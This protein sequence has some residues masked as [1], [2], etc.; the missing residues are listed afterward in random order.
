MQQIV[1]NQFLLDVIGQQWLDLMKIILSKQ[2]TTLKKHTITRNSV[3]E[4]MRGNLGFIQKDVLP[5]EFKRI[6][7]D[8][9]YCFQRRTFTY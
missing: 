1:L 2:M 7:F 9:E 4:D 3:V 8:V 5:F 6:I